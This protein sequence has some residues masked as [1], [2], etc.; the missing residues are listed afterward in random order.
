MK[1]LNVLYI[2]NSDFVSKISSD[3]YNSMNFLISPNRYLSLGYMHNYAKIDFIIDN[4]DEDVVEFSRF[5]TV[6]RLKLDL[7]E[8]KLVIVSKPEKRE[9]FDKYLYKEVFEVYDDDYEINSI[10]EHLKFSIKSITGK[11]S[12]LSN[13]VEFSFKL[14][15]WK[16]IFDI[17]VATITLITIAPIMLLTA[18]AIRLESKGKFY[19]SSK[20]VGQGYKIF[21]FYKFRSM[22]IN[23]DSKLTSLKHLNQYNN[24]ENDK[25]AKCQDCDQSGSNCSALL[26]YDD[27]LICEKLYLEKK[28]IEKTST[29]LK[30]TNDPRVTR[31]GKF[32]RKT[33]IDEL[34]QL[35]NVL[36]GDMSI[37]GNRPLPVYEAEQLTSDEW[38]KRFFAPAGLT[39]LWQVEKRA[40]SSEMSPDERKQLDNQY[41]EINSLFFD[42]KLM[43][44]TIPALLQKENV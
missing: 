10:L 43:L 37:I 32:I 39:G 28:K 15:T 7:D 4:S 13:S 34:P 35:F 5:L 24:N 40:K 26:Y 23:A 19:Y 18:L 2:G 41:S 20:R 22:S 42:M 8:T 38:I 29:F 44:R 36:K 21:D 27:E 14:P 12:N 9:F 33:S 16:R 11:N 25:N 1:K 6:L 17:T 30:I 31:V 3:N